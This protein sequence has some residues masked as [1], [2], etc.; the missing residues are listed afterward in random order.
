MNKSS[1]VHR[2]RT[3][4]AIAIVAVIVL[5][6]ASRKLAWLFPEF[7]GRYPGDALWALMVL[8]MLG[9]AWPK[10]PVAWL[11]FSALSV[12]FAVELGQLYQSPWLVAIRHTA[13]G[14][15]VLGSGFDPMDLVACAAGIC[16]GYVIESILYSR[17]TAR[18][19]VQTDHSR[20]SY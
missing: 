16:I 9:F 5:G 20:G 4:Y 12:S 3:A 18:Q 13:I 10:L 6:L 19:C 8:L 11:A 1:R 17:S 2:S 7:L 14:H 15:L